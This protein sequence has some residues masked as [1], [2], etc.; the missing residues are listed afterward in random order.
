M[1]SNKKWYDSL[2][3]EQK[4]ELHK[5]RRPGALIGS[6]NAAAN[7]LERRKQRN[8]NI[9]ILE[10]H[11]LTKIEKRQRV[12]A[13]QEFKC[14]VCSMEQTWN[15]MPLKFE[16][17][18][19]DGDNS[20]NSRYNLRMICPNCHSQTDTYKVGN[21]KNPGK[22]VYSDQQIIEALQS[23]VSGYT[24]MKSLGMNPHG[25]NYVRL[26]KIIKNYGVILSYNV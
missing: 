19:I 5:K 26:R 23:N 9:L 14:S 21:N 18:H 15:D 24:A 22:K 2:N 25:G 3:A 12:L 13:E 4:A 6:A 1:A 17:D 10:W 8:E 20:N 11:S 16:L 7:R